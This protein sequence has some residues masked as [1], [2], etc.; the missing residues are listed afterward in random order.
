MSKNK[1]I[2]NKYIEKFDNY[3]F[4]FENLKKGNLNKESFHKHNHGD[5]FDTANLTAIKLNTLLKF[6]GIKNNYKILDIGC[7]LGMVSNEL[8]KINKFENV[9]ACEPSVYAAKFIKLYY[10]KINFINGGIEEIDDKFTNFFDVLYLREVS[11]FR[12]DKLELQHKLIK[13][14]RKLIKKNGIIIFEQIV[15]KGR[16]DI[17]NNVKKLKLNFKIYPSIPYFLLKNK[18]LRYLVIKNYKIVNFFLNIAD[19]IFFHH[20]KKKTFYLRLNKN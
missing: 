1:E 14:M 13:I 12:R 20:L 9:Y 15:N 19:K 16:I 18:F 4:L 7:G 3:K 17:F 11:P 5:V 6:I 8:G 2:K 10:P